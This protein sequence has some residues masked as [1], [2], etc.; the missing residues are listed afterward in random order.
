[1][2]LMDAL[3]RI[4]RAGDENS[5]ATAKLIEAAETVL[6]NLAVRTAKISPELTVTLNYGREYRLLGG[7][8]WQ[9]ADADP[10]SVIAWMASLGAGQFEARAELTRQEAYYFAAD[11]A[12]GL[13]DKIVQVIQ[14]RVKNEGDAIDALQNS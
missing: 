10:D 9:Q 14:E 5:R 2:K 1:M 8:V 7:T 6:K 12:A 11:I 13:L 4:Q 3:N